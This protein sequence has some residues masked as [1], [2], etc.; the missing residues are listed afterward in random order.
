M[1]LKCNAKFEVKQTSGL[2]NDMR[3]FANFYQNIRMCQNWDFDGILLLK[4][5][6]A[7]VKNLQRSYM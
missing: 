5:E 7:L 2:K 4:V 1:I 3:N 6:N